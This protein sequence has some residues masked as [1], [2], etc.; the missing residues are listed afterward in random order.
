MDRINAAFTAALAAFAEAQ[1]IP[2]GWSNISFVPPLAPHL[3]PALRPEMPQLAELGSGGLTRHNGSF[4][5]DVVTPA[6]EGEARARDMASALLRTFK[7]G[8][9]LGLD[10]LTLKT[11]GAA[12]PAIKDGRYVLPVVIPYY[13]YLREE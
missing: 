13:A 12:L 6:G 9:S 10:G 3:R 5:V 1:G 2:V 7:R 11:G 4:V 8:Q